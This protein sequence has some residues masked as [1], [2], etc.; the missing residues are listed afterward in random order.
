MV[1]GPMA[2]PI[3]RVAVGCGVCVGVN[4]AGSTVSDGSGLA[5]VDV[6]EICGAEH[7]DSTRHKM[8][9]INNSRSIPNCIS[10]SGRIFSRARHKLT[11]TNPI[12]KK[13]NKLTNFYRESG[14]GNNSD[15]QK[16]L[17]KMLWVGPIDH[18]RRGIAMLAG[19]VE[20]SAGRFVAA[21]LILNDQGC[22]GC[23]LNNKGQRPL[24]ANPG[25]EQKART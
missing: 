8:Q 15:L 16:T 2:C 4:V 7:A 19:R 3:V 18:N 13:A 11:G 5:A 23:P 10:T 22:A 24:P 25:F 17:L 1:Y 20:Q 9:T 6:G 21:R 12:N 14:C